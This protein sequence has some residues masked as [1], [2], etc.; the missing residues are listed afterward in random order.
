MGWVRTYFS[1][2]GAYGRNTYFYGIL[3]TWPSPRHVLW[4]GRNVRLLCGDDHR[5]NIE[6]AVRSIWEPS[7]AAP[8]KYT[9]KKHVRLSSLL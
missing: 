7:Y 9:P 2:P 5:G 3:P 6:T 1:Y 4:G 8:A